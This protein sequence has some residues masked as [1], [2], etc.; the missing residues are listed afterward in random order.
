VGRIRNPTVGHIGNLNRAS[1]LALIGSRGP[2]SRAEIARQLTVS[3]ATVTSVTRDLVA[4]GIVRVVDRI[5]SGG[6]RPGIRL[7]LVPDAGHVLGVKIAPDHLAGVIVDLGGDVVESFGSHFEAAGPRIVE[8]IVA[9][10][11]PVIEGRSRLSPPLLGI[12]LGVPGLVDADADGTV[13]SPS[14]GW[15]R[16]ALRSVLQQRLGLPVL[17]E[18]DVNTLAIAERL[19]GRGR[20]VDNFV[21]VTIGRGVGLG[22]VARGDLYRGARGGAG[23][24][25]HVTVRPDGPGCYCGRRGCLEALVA[26]PALLR[27][28]I[29]ARILTADGT[30][31]GL[32]A[33]A[34][35]GDELA[36]GIYAD[37]GVLLGRAVATVVNL[38]DPQLVLLSG[39][40][41]RA[42]RHL[43]GTFE[44]ALR[45]ALFGPL[46]SVPVE[47]DPW[48]DAR[49]ARGA[50]ALVFRST[51]TAS[52]DE[53][54]VEVDV[55]DRLGATPAHASPGATRAS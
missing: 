20:D 4:R 36:R 15:G 27:Q 43:E 2:I 10:L 46:A 44:P 12:G 26:D 55:R 47:I 29:A 22:I 17:I 6:G 37:A 53:L 41:I 28:A 35:G 45:S 31:D 52:L 48:D 54:P 50:A 34:D 14:L 38:L 51:F 16:L 9:V 39:E 21:T 42:W 23:E 33:L 3:P 40:G 13:E 1:V 19:Y 32:V 7:A 8:R 30:I 5:P 11:R 24:L 49:W 25:G 18:N